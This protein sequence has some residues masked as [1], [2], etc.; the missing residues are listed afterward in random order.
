[1]LACGKAT[2]TFLPRF[3]DC[4]PPNERGSVLFHFKNF[5]PHLY[6]SPST[7]DWILENYR[8]IG[9]DLL[10]ML[11]F[12]ETTK[13]LFAYELLQLARVCELPSDLGLFKSASDLLLYSKQ[14]SWIEDNLKLVPRQGRLKFSQFLE[15][16]LEL[17]SFDRLAL[18]E[19]NK[20]QIINEPISC[21][22]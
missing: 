13:P 2:A 5:L 11:E 12:V 20:D 4:I 18:I 14:K 8:F 16:I 7:C 1:M 3:L 15:L 19:K 17:T 6:P 22:L 21:W 9:E 10:D